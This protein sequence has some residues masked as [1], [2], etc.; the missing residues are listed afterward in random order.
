MQHEGTLRGLGW[1]ALAAALFV[2]FV[3]ELCGLLG[4]LS[5]ARDMWSLLAA[6]ATVAFGLL[7]LDSGARARWGWCELEIAE[8]AI[9][10]VDGMGWRIRRTTRIA[11]PTRGVPLTAVLEH[12]G[13]P[14]GTY[15]LTVHN[16]EP[17]GQPIAIARGLDIDRDTL[18]HVVALLERWDRGESLN[19]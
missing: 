14:P 5:I 4:M 1:L 6:V 16:G 11:R 13:D 7:A 2:G 10:V 8:V 18:E 9:T 15:W 12:D 19:P 17:F 3:V